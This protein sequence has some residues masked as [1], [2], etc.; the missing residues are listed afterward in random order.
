MDTSKQNSASKW[1]MFALL[2]LIWGSSFILMLAGMKTLSPYEVAS[3]RIASA[4]LVLFPFATAAIKTIPKQQRLLVV[5]SGILGSFIPAFLFCIAETRIDSSLAGILN[6]LTPLFT[7]IIG[8]SFFKMQASAAKWIGIFIG[9]VGLVL[10]PFAAAKGINFTEVQYGL[11]VLLATVC[12]A[13]NVNMVSK[14]LKGISPLHIASLAF[15]SLLPFCL[16]VL[17]YLGF[18]HK[19]AMSNTNQWYSIGASAVLGIFGTAIASIIFYRLVKLAGSIFASLV[20]YGIPFVA[21]AWGLAF[22][23]AITLLQIGCLC[24]ILGGVYLVNKK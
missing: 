8:V 4:G 15:A 12:Y 11:L 17:S 7:I 16:I 9:F 1:L 22:D 2:A 20:T 14:F 18:W 19:L 6:A 23:E 3:I 13:L 5:L 24:I 10:L 21:V